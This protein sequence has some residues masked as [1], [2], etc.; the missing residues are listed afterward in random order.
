MGVDAFA[1]RLQRYAQPV[2][3]F[4]RLGIVDDIIDD[5]LYAVLCPSI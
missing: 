4:Y 2:A 1:D 3:M 5:C